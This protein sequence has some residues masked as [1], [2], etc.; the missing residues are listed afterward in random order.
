MV[1]ALRGPAFATRVGFVAPPD[2]RLVLVIKDERDLE[3]AKQL[4]VVGYEQVF[5]PDNGGRP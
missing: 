4:A 5:V 2:A 3:A 1:V